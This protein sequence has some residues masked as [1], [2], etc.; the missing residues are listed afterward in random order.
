MASAVHADCPPELIVSDFGIPQPNRLATSIEHEWWDEEPGR[1]DKG[2]RTT[3][4]FAYAAN[5]GKTSIATVTASYTHLTVE[6]AQA[7][8]KFNNWDDVKLTFRKG[9]GN[10]ETVLDWLGVSLFLPTGNSEKNIGTGRWGVGLNLSRVDSVSEKWDL[11]AGGEVRYFNDVPP[12][13]GEVG[14]I[15]Y[16][17]SVSVFGG[18]YQHIGERWSMLYEVEYVHPRETHVDDGVRLSIGPG[19]SFGSK[20]KGRRVLQVRYRKDIATRGKPQSLTLGLYQGF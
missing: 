3:G 6:G 9:L 10:S 1:L 5:V 18:A 8:E 4:T 14:G 2:S 16:V 19:Y 17:P 15:N 11:Y 12:P 7:T 13:P 20:E